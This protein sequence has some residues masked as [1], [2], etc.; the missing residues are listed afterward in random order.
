MNYGFISFDA[1]SPVPFG[2]PLQFIT[3]FF[4]V[5]NSDES[6]SLCRNKLLAKIEASKRNVVF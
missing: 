5:I 3:S 2:I 1:Q 6:Q 4:S